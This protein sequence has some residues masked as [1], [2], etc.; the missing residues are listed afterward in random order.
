[1][2]ASITASAGN[3]RRHSSST[4]GGDGN[5]DDEN[6]GDEDVRKPSASSMW[7]GLAISQMKYVDKDLV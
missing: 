1:M 2:A 5:S 7:T 6:S 3:K 4:I